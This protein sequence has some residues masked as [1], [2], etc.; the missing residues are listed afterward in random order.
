MQEPMI[1]ANMPGNMVDSQRRTISRLRTRLF[2]ALLPII[3]LALI[4]T[5][6]FWLHWASQRGIVLGYPAPEV[7][8]TSSRPGTVLLNQSVQF[9]A[10][11]S[12]R[13]VSY[14]WNFGDGSYGYGQKVSHSYQRLSGSQNN[15]MY[16]VTITVRD[17][18]GQASYDSTSLRVM[19]PP[20]TASFT[21]TPAGYYYYVT[22][23]ASASS[24]DQSTSIVSYHWDFGDGS[25]DTVSYPQYSRYYSSAGTYTV[26]LTVTD[27]TSQT[28]Q[29]ASITIVVQ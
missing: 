29:P 16:T 23:D 28:S 10:S 19:P 27:A 3:T 8:I 22:F 13:D 6:I 17:A 20:P 1:F 11:G 7:H 24:A 18:I 21:Y 15:Y 5:S 2:L 14:V 12:G 26:T 9:S 25:S 4:V